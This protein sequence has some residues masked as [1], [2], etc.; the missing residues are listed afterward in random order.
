[1]CIYIY[2]HIYIHMVEK[3]VTTEGKIG[4]SEGKDA[5]ICAYNTHTY[6]YMYI[7]IYIYVYISIY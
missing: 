4:L 5:G 3:G 2:I 1:M 7:C 6:I